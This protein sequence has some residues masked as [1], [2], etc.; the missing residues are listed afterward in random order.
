MF[1]P[2]VAVQGGDQFPIGPLL[3]GSRNITLF[4]GTER[5]A[6]GRCRRA[7]LRRATVCD[8]LLLSRDSLAVEEPFGQAAQ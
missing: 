1:A 2:M 4:V 3:P 6:Y 7:F 5:G 8:H